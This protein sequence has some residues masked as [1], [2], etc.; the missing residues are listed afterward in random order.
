MSRIIFADGSDKLEL[1]YLADEI[2][3]EYNDKAETF[4]QTHNYKQLMNSIIWKEARDF[5]L[6]CKRNEVGILKRDRCETILDSGVMHH[7]HYYETKI[8]NLE[9]VS[10][11]CGA[12]HYKTHKRKRK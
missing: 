3:K 8:F 2:L 11:I 6:D 5:I 4:L 7:N 1:K 10:A 12:C 9:S